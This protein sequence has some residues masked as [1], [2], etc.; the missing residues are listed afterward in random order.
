MP[1]VQFFSL[2]P[3]IGWPR[4]ILIVW[5]ISGHTCDVCGLAFVTEEYLEKHKNKHREHQT[6]GKK[7]KCTQCYYSTDQAENLAKHLLTHVAEKP[8]KCGTCD[9]G[10]AQARFLKRHL[11]RHTAEKLYQCTTC[12]KRLKTARTLSAHMKVHVGI[13][14]Y[15]CNFCDKSFNFCG[16]LKRHLKLHAGVLDLACAHCDYKT[17]DPTS[18][19]H[20]VI[21][22]HT[23]EFPHNCTVCGK[24]F[25]SPG[26]LKKHVT[27]HHPW[28]IFILFGRGR[29]VF[30]FSAGL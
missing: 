6:E 30:S 11:R 21:R 29:V 19:K 22:L 1:L 25:L 27:K 17:S 20:H 26:V 13:K 14:S 18:F 5:C 3:Y 7:N 24:G 16:S 4:F 10:F 2:P 9:Q 28:G 23:H 15:Q 12:D 8:F